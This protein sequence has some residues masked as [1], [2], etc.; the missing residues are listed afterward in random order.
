[1]L[2]KVF[3]AIRDVGVTNVTKEIIRRVFGLEYSI[4]GIPIK[5]N[6]VFGL[7]TRLLNKGFK[8]YVEN[9]NIIVKT[10]YGLIG[11]DLDDIELLGSLLEPFNEVFSIVDVNNGV[12]LDIGA[13]IGDTPLFFI[14]KG[15]SKV[16]AYEPVVKHY[17]Y[18]IKNLERNNVLNNVTPINRGVW[19]YKGEITIPYNGLTTGLC[20]SDSQIRIEVEEFSSILKTVFEKEGGIDLV[21]M[22][23]EG[24]EY[25]LINTPI[26]DILKCRNYIVEI[27]GSPYLIIDLMS[28]IGYSV[29]LLRV[30]KELVGIY[31]FKH[32][33]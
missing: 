5:S 4:N 3:S 31:Y 6:R 26:E 23:C 24:C 22:D 14:S 21:K 7:I 33:D 16:Y 15:A 17:N 32:S 18:L 10:P 9:H 11:V 19:L 25:V 29:K 28:K 27:H 2:R 8:V 13:Y 20:Y 1:M 12:V 30:L